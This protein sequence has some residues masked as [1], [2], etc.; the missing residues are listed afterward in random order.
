MYQCRLC[1]LDSPRELFKITNVPSNIQRLFK[2]SELHLDGSVD[3][4]ILEC[5]RCQFVQ[6]KPIVSDAYY[7]D[8]LMTT[9]HSQQQQE[10][11]SRQ[12]QDFVNR[13]QLNGKLLIE[14]GCGDGSY[15]DHL[16]KE[17]ANALGVEPSARFR[18]LAVSRGYD[19]RN[20]KG[21]Y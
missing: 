9:T 6:I 2:E 16:S 17:G 20:L 8:Y 1:G 5:E 4:D 3:L 14:V 11:Q 13:F 10:Y 7:D 12:A 19:G 21:S 15:L 18:E